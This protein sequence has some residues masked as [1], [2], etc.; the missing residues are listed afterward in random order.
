MVHQNF[1]LQKTTPKRRC[2]IQQYLKSK[3][4]VLLNEAAAGE[5]NENCCITVGCFGAMRH[6]ILWPPDRESRGRGAPSV[7][8]PRSG[9]PKQRMPAQIEPSERFS[10]IFLFIE[11]NNFHRFPF[12][13]ACPAFFF[14]TRFPMLLT[15]L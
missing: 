14:H 4:K 15:S 1:I 13:D 8:R 12:L 2:P 6:A 7:C 10:D 9:L 11:K 3:K 5:S